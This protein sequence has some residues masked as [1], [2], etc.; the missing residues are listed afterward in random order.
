M[1]FVTK[2]LGSASFSFEP[3]GS[4]GTG[5]NSKIGLTSGSV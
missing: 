2:A 4:V 5:F 1:T 3:K